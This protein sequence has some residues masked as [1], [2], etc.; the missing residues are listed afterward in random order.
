M[1]GLEGAQREDHDEREAGVRLLDCGCSVADVIL[2]SGEAVG[3]PYVSR[4]F[5][6]GWWG[7][8]VHPADAIL[9]TVLPL[10]SLRKVPRRAIALLRMTSR[11]DDIAYR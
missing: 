11:T 3:G 4:K 6:S 8:T 5:R 1:S 7:H 2:N 10:Q 9:A